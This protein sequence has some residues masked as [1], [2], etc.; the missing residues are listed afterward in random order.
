MEVSLAVGEEIQLDAFRLH[1]TT[2]NGNV[3]TVPGGEKPRCVNT[4]PWRQMIRR[5]TQ[6]S[7]REDRFCNVLKNWFTKQGPAEAAG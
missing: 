3:K 7:R 4:K 5:M 2:I 6:N 1:L